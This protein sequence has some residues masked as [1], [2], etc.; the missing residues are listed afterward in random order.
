MKTL[1][2]EKVLERSFSSKDSKKAY[3][4]CCKWLA[5]NV[6]SKEKELGQ[7][8]TYKVVK[9]KESDIPTFKVI[10]YASLDENR[11]KEKHC[12]ACKEMHNLF[13]INEQYDCN[14]CSVNSYQKRRENM[15][16]ILKSFLKEKIEL[17]EFK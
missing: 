3:L 2:S 5:K 11:V 8:L 17:L 7:N 9:D 14:K 10:L 12:E 13:Y 1:F 6:V 4:K 16:G 15:L